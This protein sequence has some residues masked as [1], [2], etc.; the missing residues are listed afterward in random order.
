MLERAEMT[1]RLLNVRFAPFTESDDELGFHQATQVLRSASA[2]EAF[3]KAHR[4]MSLQHVVEF[5]LMSP[6]FPRSVLFCLRAA[7]S[8]L[9]D[10]DSPDRLSRAMRVLGR[11]RA[12]LEFTDVGELLTTDVHAFLDEVQDDVRRAADLVAIQFFRHTDEFAVF[13][14]L[15]R[16]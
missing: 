13:H 8:A 5:L 7:E 1:C 14:S 11:R 3:R 9:H 4:S 16:V 15:E 10:V 2:S 6:T 12:D